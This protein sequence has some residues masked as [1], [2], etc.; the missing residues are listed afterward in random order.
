MFALHDLD[1]GTQE[2][3]RFTR[4][5]ARADL[6]VDAMFGTGFH[7]ALDGTPGWVATTVRASGCRTLAIDIPS[8]VDGTTGAVAGEAVTADA[9]VCFV[10]SKPGLLF[11]PGRSH[12]GRVHVVDIGIA[13]GPSSIHV[14]EVSDLRLPGRHV[15]AHK[16]SS[17]LM[18]FGGSIGIE[19]TLIKD[20]NDQLGHLHGD[21]LLREVSARLHAITRSTDVR[22][23][24]GGDEFLVILTDTPVLGAQQV[25][26][27]VRQEMAKIVVSAG[28]RRV[29]VTVSAGVAAALPGEMDPKALIGRADEALYRAKRGGRDRFC[30]AFPPA[31]T[32][33][34][35]A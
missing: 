34:M 9:T 1:A 3:D 22:C 27:T 10:A 29:A 21:E 26:E 6:V 18:I 31:G 8:G 35:T 19:Y 16:W 24:F 7:G 23:R 5:L 15:Q 28:D 30:V 17:G 14:P 20:V 13:V 4:A 2:R 32:S 12:A 11:E 33:A 25:A